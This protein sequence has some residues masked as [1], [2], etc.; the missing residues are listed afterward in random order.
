MRRNNSSIE[1]PKK[2]SLFL[3]RISSDGEIVKLS[4]ETISNSRQL[5]HAYC[6]GATAK[7]SNMIPANTSLSDQVDDKDIVLRNLLLNQKLA[8]Q[9]HK[10]AV[11]QRKLLAEREAAKQRQ[12]EP[13]EI[14]THTA[15]S[16]DGDDVNI[17][18]ME[19]ENE[20]VVESHSMDDT[21]ASDVPVA[22]EPRKRVTNIV[23]NIIANHKTKQTSGKPR[24]PF[25]V[26]TMGPASPQPIK[27]ESS[28]N[29]YCNKLPAYC[30]TLSSK[31]HPS[32]LSEKESFNTLSTVSISDSNRNQSV[33]VRYIV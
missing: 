1:E 16:C 5:D 33:Q 17:V 32:S 12:E 23:T 14:S 10:L 9:I 30:T 20:V 29:K 18:D 6:V 28:D 4:S 21:P 25:K 3:P 27:I 11:Q 13:Q 7:P 31:G 24:R 2:N 19:I 26:I 8:K 22:N 15:V